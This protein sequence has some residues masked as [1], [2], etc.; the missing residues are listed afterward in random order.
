MGSRSL[1]EVMALRGSSL[2]PQGQLSPGAVGARQT[3]EIGSSLSPT[4]AVTQEAA[5]AMRLPPTQAF[6]PGA[7]A[8]LAEAIA[9]P[10]NVGVELEGQAEEQPMA[11]RRPRSP[12]TTI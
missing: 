3:L 4:Q 9:A 7:V 2:G 10:V 12:R 1:S 6:S 5:Q 8:A 11:R